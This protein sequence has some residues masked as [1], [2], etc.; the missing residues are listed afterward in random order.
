MKH[1][2]AK[3]LEFTKAGFTDL[4]ILNTSNTGSNAQVAPGGAQTVPPTVYN[5]FSVGFTTQTC[6]LT[7]LAASDAILHALIDIKT[8]IVGPTGSPTAQVKTSVGA[9]AITPTAVVNST[10]LGS[11]T[12]N[13]VV[14]RTISSGGENLVLALA[15]GGGNGAAAT[16]GEIWVWANILRGDRTTLQ[17]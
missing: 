12:D 16:A 6:I 8:A 4:F 10:V 2:H 17:G 9:V 1:Y 13:T 11:V 5:D 14:G 3:E 15:A 7:A